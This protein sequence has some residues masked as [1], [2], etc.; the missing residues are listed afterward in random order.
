MNYLADVA[1]GHSSERQARRVY[2]RNKRELPGG[3]LD[4]A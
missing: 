4:G 3:A 2:P 1:G